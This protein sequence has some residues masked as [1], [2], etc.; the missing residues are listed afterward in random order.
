M[1]RLSGNCRREIGKKALELNGN[2]V[3]GCRQYFD[4]ETDQRTITARSIG[5][6]VKIV[7]TERFNLDRPNALGSFP[8]QSRINTNGQ[9][10]VIISPRK[11]SAT[12]SIEDVNTAAAGEPA[13]PI[14]DFPALSMPSSHWRSVDPILLTIT[15]FPKNSILAMGGYVCATS[16]KIFDSDDEDL[17]DSWWIELRDEIKSHAQKLSCNCVLGYTEQVSIHDDLVILFVSGTAAQLDLSSQGIAPIYN[18]RVG[19]PH[20]GV[21]DDDK[22][23]LLGDL[24]T[25]SYRETDPRHGSYTSPIQFQATSQ[26]QSID[27]GHRKPYKLSNLRGTPII[28]I[29]LASH[30]IFRITATNRISQWLSTGAA[31][32]RKGLSPKSCWLQSSPQ[33]SSK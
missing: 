11:A 8:S 28:L 17:R 21:A 24:Q 33:S 5:T 18:H 7:K 15:S 29:Q 6:A 3:I 4:L 27:D 31:H 12:A 19:D 9:E 22:R 1:F 30:A 2:A 26:P 14:G 20:L 25:S 32:A 16:I 10:S 23:G 13:G